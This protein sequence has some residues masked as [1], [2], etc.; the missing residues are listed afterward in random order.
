MSRQGLWARRTASSA[1]AV[2]RAHVLGVA[3]YSSV[4]CGNALM[5]PV[6]ILIFHVQSLQIELKG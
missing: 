2:R 6:S 5:T 1:H 3:G 4:L